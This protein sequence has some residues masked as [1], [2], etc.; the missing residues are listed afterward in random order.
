MFGAAAMFLVGCAGKNAQVDRSGA[1]SNASSSKA[2]GGSDLITR[3]VLFGNPD[4]AGP[5][6]SPD[7][8]QIAFLAPL[9]GVLNVWIAP[10]DNP[11]AA[12][13][14]TK[15]SNRG[16]RRYFWAYTNQHIIYMQDKGGDENWRVYSVDL[17]NNQERD[18]TPFEK[19]AAQVE[20]VSY[21]FPDEILIGLNNRDAKYHDL[22]RVNIRTGQMTLVTQNDEFVGFLT[23]D[24]YNVRFAMKMTPDGGSD[25]LKA[26]DGG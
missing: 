11:S 14:V 10:S 23:D 17:S 26:G 4:R 19:V 7:G 5:Q 1:S 9:D 12:R 15:D 25:L 24:D 16:I 18:L 22:H 2:K 13:A 21:K 8:K 3:E 6:V 20:E